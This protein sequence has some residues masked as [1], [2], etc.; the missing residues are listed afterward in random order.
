MNLLQIYILII[1][2]LL[3]TS[4]C[5]SNKEE[6]FIISAEEIKNDR[7]LTQLISQQGLSASIKKS[8]TND[9]T[10]LGEKLFNDKNLSGN[11]DISCSTCHNKHF[12]SS[13]GL[14]LSIG[15]GGNGV[16]S[17]RTQEN[18]ISKT[19]RRNSPSL[20]NL[21][22]E[23][24]TLSFYDG[25][26]QLVEGKI[27][28]PLNIDN[29][30]SQFFNKVI[31]AQAIFPLISN[32]EMLGK[33]GTNDIATTSNQNTI[34]SN[35]LTKRILIDEE[36][37]SM[38]TSAYPEEKNINIGHVGN[39]IGT[40]IKN[41]FIVTNTPYDKYL[42]GDKTALTNNQ[43]NGMIIFMTRGQCITCHSGENLTDNKL[44][45]VGVP[46]IYP[47]LSNVIDDTGRAEVTGR[48]ADL[49]RFKTPGLRNIGKSAPYM[50]NGSLANLEVV[51]EHYNNV[52]ESLTNYRI[53]TTLQLPYEEEIR[54]DKNVSRQQNRFNAIDNNSLK[55]GLRLTTADK[56]DLVDFLRNA[57]SN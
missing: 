28:T 24:Q 30:I 39:A 3:L 44:H 52:R 29:L 27:S 22:Q 19:I 53:S 12:G 48:I 26:I 41:N 10:K 33:V 55:R 38:F 18:G 49:Y 8:L 7:R 50:H 15:T 2:I 23:E 11:R 4:S 57:L 36:Y 20:F 9:I 17:S 43:K 45:S 1:A 35:I 51:V 25:R 56:S 46:H 42:Q 40:F 21:G 16:G 31:D 37:A 54:V 32:E 34:W 47:S 13:D 14:S 5:G 6:G